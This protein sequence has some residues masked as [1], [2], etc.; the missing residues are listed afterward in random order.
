MRRREDN[1]WRKEYEDYI[2][3]LE[4]ENYFD[5]NCHYNDKGYC[6]KL[7]VAKATIEAMN[8]IEETLYFMSE[9]SGDSLKWATDDMILEIN[10]I[11]PEKDIFHVSVHIAPITKIAN[12][13][14]VENITYF[15]KIQD[16]YISRNII[17][18]SKCPPIFDDGEKVLEEF[19]DV[20]RIFLTE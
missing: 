5:N 6:K 17:Y 10:N 8:I 18:S 20:I 19:I 9:E 14:R 4:D 13:E 11:I 2:N 3:Y 15:Y 7:E 1:D 12:H 16:K